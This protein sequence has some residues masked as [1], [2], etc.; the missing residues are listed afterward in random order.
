MVFE[1]L[2][3]SHVAME[4]SATVRAKAKQVGEK[5]A[6]KA[7]KE[8]FSSEGAAFVEYEF[9]LGV[10]GRYQPTP[11]FF[12]PPVV[13][14]YAVADPIILPSADYFLAP[15]IPALTSSTWQND[16]EEVRQYGDVN[17]TVRTAYQTGVARYM[18][19][20]LFGGNPE[21][22]IGTYTRTA[23]ELIAQTGKGLFDSAAILYLI[24]VSSFDVFTSIM[25]SKKVYDSWRP[26]TPIRGGVPSVPSIVP[27][28]TWTPLLLYN[29]NQEYPAGHGGVSA[30]QELVLKRAFGADNFTWTLPTFNPSIPP[31]TFNSITELKIAGSEARIWAG[32]HFRFSLTGSWAL[33]EQVCGYVYDE[34]CLHNSCFRH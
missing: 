25:N 15:P 27:D 13:Q 1:D 33:A 10:E 24:S 18:D 32:I 5:W 6:K 20:V 2:L 34:I 7:V 23:Q 29:S 3:R 8:V 21:G 12:R 31:L 17:S 26:I 14:Q 30:C 16:L 11:P 28:P 4:P 22:V 9:A 19:G